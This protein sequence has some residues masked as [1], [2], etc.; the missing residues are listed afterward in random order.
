MNTTAFLTE[1]GV[2]GEFDVALDEPASHIVHLA[3][4]RGAI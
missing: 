2:E 4:Q 3:E 1:H